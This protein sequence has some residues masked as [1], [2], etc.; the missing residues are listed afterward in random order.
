MKIAVLTP[1]HSLPVIQEVLQK[2]GIQSQFELVVY[3]SLTQLPAQYDGVKDRVQGILVTGKLSWRFLMAK[4][5]DLELPVTCISHSKLRP[6]LYLMRHLMEHPDIPLEETF[7]DFLHELGD[8]AIYAD[9]LPSGQLPHTI[10]IT[11][12][13]DRLIEDTAGHVEQLYRQG[14]IKMAYLTITQLYILLKGRGI[15]CQHI[16]IQPE[17]ILQAAQEALRRGCPGPDSGCA[18]AVI[19]LE[20]GNGQER[21]SELE[22][23][24]AT[25]MKALVDFK[26]TLSSPRA[27]SII[28]E[29][30]MIEVTLTMPSDCLSHQTVKLLRGL[31]EGA[32]INAGAGLG[33]DAVSAREQSVQAL[34]YAR[35]F[36]AGSAFSWSHNQLKGPLLSPACVTLDGVLLTLSWDTAK[37]LNISPRNHIRLLILFCQAEGTITSDRVAEFLNI[38][39]RSANRILASLLAGGVLEELPRLDAQGPGRPTRRYVLTNRLYAT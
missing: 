30:Q 3:D 4:R 15:P 13:T 38:T 31:E 10:S 24:E 26:R 7:C 12:A 18:A 19:L 11:G 25:L 35:S 1:R 27:M 32:Y 8:Y 6:C 5:P 36:G 22:Y 33:P 34:G 14:K 28:R 39:A 17:D 2:N 23:R 16:S 9:I 37:R 20:Y 29:A 21:E